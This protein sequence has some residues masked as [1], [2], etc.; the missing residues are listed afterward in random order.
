M[1]FLYA[2]HNLPYFDSEIEIMLLATCHR[3]L[4]DYLELDS[5]TISSK[6]SNTCRAY[7][8]MRVT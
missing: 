8:N 3:I 2:N 6:L 4:L 7:S 5:A 1:V